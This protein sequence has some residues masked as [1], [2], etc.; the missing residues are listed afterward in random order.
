MCEICSKLTKTTPGRRQDV[1]LLL[2]WN[3]FHTL[4]FI[5]D[6]E[7]VNASKGYAILYRCSHH[8]NIVKNGNKGE[9]WCQWVVMCYERLIDLKSDRM[10]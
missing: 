7:R 10:L 6:Y 4:L 5:V 3:R 9:H 8:V 1:V 2:T